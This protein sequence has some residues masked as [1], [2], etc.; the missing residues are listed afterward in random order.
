VDID[1][2]AAD[3]ARFRFLLNE[4]AGLRL[5][6]TSAE[7]LAQRLTERLRVLRI[8]SYREYCNFLENGSEAAREELIQ[9]L[10]RLTT[11]ETYFFRHEEQLD[12]LKTTIFQNLARQNARKRRLRLWSAGCSTGEE[13]YTLAIMLLESGLFL[14][15]DVQVLGTDLCATRVERAQSGRYEPGAFRAMS[16]KARERWF[17][18]QD[19]QWVV[20]PDLKRLCS[21]E[22]Q[23][24]CNSAATFRV[25]RFDVVL[26]RNVL[27]YLDDRAR[28][29]VVLTFHERLI[30]GGYLLL[31]HAEVLPRDDLPCEFSPIAHELA[32]QKPLRQARSRSAS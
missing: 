22:V 23:N 7:T 19:K 3:L 18:P 25:G 4:H 32:Y 15:W 24:L 9:V 17:E 8:A 10:D 12:L 26:C 31:G 30:P 27:L 11:G 2:A 21:F 20:S 5:D 1:L 16:A 28:R 14:G 29:Q 6:L 13:A